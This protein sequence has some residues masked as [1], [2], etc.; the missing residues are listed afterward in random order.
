VTERLWERLGAASGLAASVLIMASIFVQPAPPSV[1]AGVAALSRYFAE[2]GP[3]IRLSALLTTLAAVA[4]LWFVGYLRHLLQR[5]EGG[6]EAFSPVVMV[7]GVSLA[8]VTMIATTSKV[9]LA[10]P[11][12]L[13]GPTVSAL[14]A[15]DALS[16]GP[17]GLL[18]ALFA[19]TAATAMVR[20]ELAAPWLGW[21]GFVA[22]LAGL[23]VGVTAF[24]SIGVVLMLL[25]FIAVILFIVW[26]GA[27]SLVMLLRPEVDRIGAAGHPVF[28]R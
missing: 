6:V 16:I 9:V 21:S 13:D 20:R 18:I 15:L 2:H 27:S 23:A 14:V 24:V 3:V 10:S 25:D 28:A 26:V 17:A 19:G 11:F 4:F 8:T 1:G 22:A 12:V 7:A 5:A